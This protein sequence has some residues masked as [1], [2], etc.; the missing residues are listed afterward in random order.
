MGV[1]ADIAAQHCAGWEAKL[2]NSYRRHW[3]TRLFRH[4][5]I[6]NAV[7]ILKSGQLLSRSDIAN[8]LVRDVAPDQII[9][10]TDAAHGYVRLYFRPRTPTQY[11]IEG[12]RRED[13]VWNDKH[14]PVLC[15][16][17]FKF[18]NL[19]T[20]EATHFSNGNMQIPGMP[21]LNGDDGFANLDFDKIYHEGPYDTNTQADIKVWRCAE[22]LSSEPL[23]LDESLEAVVCRSH[24]ERQ[25]LLH[26][27]GN[28][29]ANWAHKLMVVTQP[30]YFNAEFAFVEAA[31]LNSDGISIRFHPRKRT[32]METWVSAEARC[33]DDLAILH[34]W[35]RQEMDLRKTWNFA[36]KPIEARYQFTLHIDGERAFQSI[37]SYG[38]APY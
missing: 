36:F 28:Q 22:V 30:G 27:L 7:E 38:E 14:A 26:L 35:P 9:N 23:Q 4:E 5:V 12:I 2:Q 24:A 37:L 19:M 10:N 15:M 1:S 18:H 34:K 8:G 31:D 16:F 3:P 32:P 29:G 17:V 6:E 25:T 13:E 20:R 33:L 21:I 11:R